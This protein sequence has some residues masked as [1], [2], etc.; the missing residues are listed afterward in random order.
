MIARVA[1]GK[2]CRPV[3]DNVIRVRFQF[4]DSTKK[5]LRFCIVHVWLSDA[6]QR[7]P[8]SLVRAGHVRRRSLDT[9]Y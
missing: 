3:D 4:C 1:A 2:S 8:L 9:D 7:R 6:A 5:R